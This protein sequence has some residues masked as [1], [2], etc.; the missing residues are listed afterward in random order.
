MSRRR[1]AQ[2]GTSPGT[3][4]PRPPAR[5]ACTLCQGR[6]A[7]RPAVPPGG[8]NPINSHSRSCFLPL[9]WRETWPPARRWSHRT[10]L[11]VARRGGPDLSH[12]AGARGSP[13]PSL[14]ASSALLG[15]V[16]G[17]GGLPSS[18][19]CPSPQMI[20][21]SRTLIESADAVYGKLI[22]AQQAG[23]SQVGR[24]SPGDAPGCRPG[25]V[26]G[27]VGVPCLCT[28]LGARVPAGLGSGGLAPG[29]GPGRGHSQACRL[30]W[31]CACMPVVCDGGRDV[32][33]C[34]LGGWVPGPEF[35]GRAA[36]ASRP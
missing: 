2:L 30:F 28:G 14:L 33:V 7:G 13:C 36:R 27:G 8:R 26:P 12:R 17:A 11:C 29:S 15:G 9:C 20:Q 23:G 35:S 16:R 18:S 6:L 22:Q 3:P 5:A 10:W 4:Q 31:P 21:T 25:H 19:R 34:T 24:P 32:R 1:L